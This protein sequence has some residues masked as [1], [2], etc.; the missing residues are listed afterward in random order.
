VFVRK[1]AVV[2]MANLAQLVNVIAPIVTSPDGLF[3]Q[4]IYHPLRLISAATQEVALDVFVDSGTHVHADRPGER[5]PYRVADL[6]PFQVL[7]VAA[8][9]DAEGRRL[10]I[11][12]VNRDPAQALDTRI[13][14]AG[15]R[16]AGPV[17]VHEVTGDSPQ[18][19]NSA[20]EPD[21][22]ATMSTKRDVIGDDL[23]VRFAPH[24]FTLLDV[25]LA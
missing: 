8:T 17:V 21:A 16:M 2:R 4:S 23:D 10:V 5:W 20:A 1:S 24:S 12:V 6:G 3:R 9:R 14:L 15:A 22:V 13:R 7:D 19:G 18:S 11:S 25:R